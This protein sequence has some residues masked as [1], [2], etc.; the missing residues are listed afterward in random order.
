VHARLDD[1]LASSLH[2]ESLRD[3]REDFIVRQRQGRDVERVKR[4]K[5]GHSDVDAKCQ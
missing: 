4:P 3:R 2:R 1:G 5:S